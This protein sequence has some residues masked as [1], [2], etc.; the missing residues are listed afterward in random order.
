MWKLD[1]DENITA[2]KERQRQPSSSSEVVTDGDMLDGD[3]LI[4]HVEIYYLLQRIRCNQVE[5]SHFKLS[6]LPD[7]HHFLLPFVPVIFHYPILF[8][9]NINTSLYS[10]RVHHNIEWKSI[11][12]PTVRFQFQMGPQHI[13]VLVFQYDATWNEQLRTIMVL[14]RICSG[15]TY[16]LGACRWQREIN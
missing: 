1:F 11:S 14:Y 5:F 4:E 15:G 13:N 10:I 2:S 9:D 8:T 16:R 7:L 12:L 3:N 6:F